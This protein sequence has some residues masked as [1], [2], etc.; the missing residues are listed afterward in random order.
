MVASVISSDDRLPGFRVE[1]LE[2]IAVMDGT[3][4]RNRR[5]RALNPDE[6]KSIL[7]ILARLDS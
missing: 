3:V 5:D 1:K 2:A 7:E 4:A 6:E